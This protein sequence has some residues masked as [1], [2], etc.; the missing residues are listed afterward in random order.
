MAQEQPNRPTPTL[1]SEGSRGS[2]QEGDE[3]F[4]ERE[5]TGGIMKL[6]E[7]LAKRVEVKKSL[8]YF[9]TES[10]VAKKQA[11]ER[12]RKSRRLA[13][14]MLVTIILAGVGAF[15]GIWFGVVQKEDDEAEIDGLDEDDGRDSALY[16]KRT[17]MPSDFPMP[18]VSPNPTN[19]PTITPRPSEP[20]PPSETPSEAPTK[21]EKVF[22]SYD[23][24]GFTWD[25]ANSQCGKPCVEWNEC[26]PGQNCFGSMDINLPCC[27]NALTLPPALTVRPTESPSASPTE[28]TPV[29][30]VTPETATPTLTPTQAPVTS[31]VTA[32]PVVQAPPP[33]T[34]A[35]IETA[36]P[37]TLGCGNG[38]VGTGLC[39]IVG[40][41]CSQF[42]F[43]G[44]G[45]EFCGPTAAPTSPGATASPTTPPVPREDG[46]SRLIAYLGN[47]QPCPTRD[48]WEHYTHIVVSFAV[49]YTWA[50]E[51][52]ECS[53]TCEI[54][55]PPICEN[56]PQPDLLREWKNAG[57]IVLLS[58]GGAGMGGS[59]EG[60]VNDCWDYCFG[61]EAQVVGRLTEII[62]NELDIDGIDI[63]YE[64][65]I[66]DHPERGFTR[67]AE[68]RMF[69]GL[70]TQGLRASLP[71]GQIITHAPL[72]NE[73]VP[74]TGYYDVLKQHS[75]MLDFLMPQ[76]YNGIVKPLENFPGALM[77]FQTLTDDMFD[78]DPTK[79]VFGFCI[80]DCSFTGSNVNGDE[81]ARVLDQLQV[82]FPCNGGAFFWVADHDVDG[83]WS[84]A[85]STQLQDNTC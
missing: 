67:G 60:D 68:A 26:G 14:L 21:L 61:R 31:P 62:V 72:D 43:C 17:A 33:T 85:V 75:N 24:C 20:V 34:P 81:A 82:F 57:K 1:P 45:V 10:K 29:P 16:A 30:T 40:E 41:C 47:W 9:P 37:T 79:V 39:P 44:T 77:N 84:S 4:G 56:A 70:L 74:G 53:E 38:N 78:S 3:E 6:D 69:L 25:N 18:T 7:D 64:Y 83:Q 66:D 46:P 59:W 50:A 12:E 54:E 5:I 8:E 32:A 27:S 36:A 65:H 15:L 48:Q 51:K 52:N 22:C 49:T 23:R 28:G 35:P 80:S 58:F 11:M 55:T 63:D 19:F 76:Y 13:V 2:S 42:G 73:L 71:P